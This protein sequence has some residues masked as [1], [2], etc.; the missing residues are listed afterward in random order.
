[1]EYDGER[2]EENMSR[3]KDDYEIQKRQEYLQK[4]NQENEAKRILGKESVTAEEIEKVFELYGEEDLFKEYLVNGAILTCEQSTR[5]PQEVKVR[6]E[7]LNFSVKDNGITAGNVPVDK[8]KVLGKLTVTQ[9]KR[10]EV[11]SEKHATTVDYCFDRNIPSFGNCK[12][13]Q[14]NDS[15]KEKLLEGAAK[16]KAHGNCKYL[17]SIMD[18]WEDEDLQKSPLQYDT[19]AGLKDGLT[20]TNML[21]C[22]HGG[23]I[24]PVTSGQ[25]DY[26][27]QEIMQLMMRKMDAYLDSDLSEAEVEKAIKYLSLFLPEIASVKEKKP[28]EEDEWEKEWADKWKDDKFDSYIKAWTFYWNQKIEDGKLYKDSQIVIRPEVVKAMIMRESGWGTGSKMNANRDV[29]QA[30]HPGDYALWILSGYNPKQLKEN[31]GKMYHWGTD[32]YV[33]WAKDGTNYSNASMR[34]GF[35]YYAYGDEDTPPDQ[36]ITT[37]EQA[38]LGNGLGVLRENVITVITGNE[39]KEIRESDAWKNQQNK[40]SPAGEYLI[41]YDRVTP[42]LSIACGIR[43]LV[44][45]TKEKGSEAG[46]VRGYNGDGTE[47]KTGKK[48][49]YAKDINTH[50]EHLIDSNGQSV[51]RLQE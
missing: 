45:Q 11:R 21:F 38:E 35:D 22:S 47:N 5:K 8:D 44:Y 1:M 36:C 30:L 4:T 25:S 49:G 16:D 14:Y 24:Y 23:W 29:M 43:Y 40:E 15:E 7:V 10:A 41:H 20:M 34:T 26:N 46:G 18:E 9:T 28:E 50:L 12:N 27:Q 19:R 33:V 32:E 13:I 37:T 31:G 42:N 39:S 17:V 48:D 3:L 51:G 6:D 2:D